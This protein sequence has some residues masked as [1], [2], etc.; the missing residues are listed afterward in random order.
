MEFTGKTVEE[1]KTK[2][3]E[4]LGISESQAE[5]TVVAEAVKGLFGKVK[6]EAV[7]DVKK[8]EEPA[9]KE[10]AAKAKKESVKTSEESDADGGVKAAAEFIEKLFDIMDVNA[11]ASITDKNVISL[12]AEESSAVIGYRGEVLDA[13]QVL[14][15]AVANIG[16]KEYEKIVVDCENYRDKRE[17]TLIALAHKLEAKATDM[18]RKVILEPMS[19]FERRIIHTALADSETV[20]TISDGKEPQ[21]YVVIVPNDLDETS[22]PYNA[23]TNHGKNRRDGKFGGRN[24]RGHNDR[25]GRDYKNRNRGERRGSGFTEEKRKSAPSFGTYL[26]NSLKD[27]NY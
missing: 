10:K 27:K 9:K 18:R 21:R 12:I 13:I 25:G 6:K 1:A 19:P 17:E 7:V 16:K 11:K 8:K 15:G 3:L 24:N 22:R 2:G 14:A 4:S 5:I 26:G 20:K 23:G